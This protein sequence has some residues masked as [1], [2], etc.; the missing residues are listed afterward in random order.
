MKILITGATGFIGQALVAKLKDH[1][2]FLVGRD[3]TKL[4][5]IFTK[6]KDLLT[7][8]Q[9]K[10][11]SDAFFSEL[12]W[13]INL[14]GANIAEKRW[15]TKRKKVIIHSRVGSSRFLASRLAPLGKAAPTLFNASA[16]GFYGLQKTP[17]SN[18]DLGP[19]F[20]EHSLPHK[21]QDFLTNITHQWETALDLAVKAGV[22]VVMMRFGVVLGPGGM[23]N[24]LLLPYQFCMG[25]RVGSGRQVISWIALDDLIN[26]ILFIHQHQDIKG[27][28]NF[29]SPN[30][31][32]QFTFAKTL[33]K[34]LHRPC[35]FPT[36]APL[37]KLVYGQMGDELLLHGTHVSPGILSE[38]D[39][40]Y[41]HPD[42]KQAIEHGLIDD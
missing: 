27:P 11:Q 22:R 3:Q 38:L 40:Q 18:Q 33:A 26:A 14:C 20:N 23:L 28:V 9:L 6:Q 4:R 24:Q 30:A 37:V 32:N 42:I 5:D 21:T 35:V 34:T 29:V 41:T 15:S 8:P 7:W 17:K 12:D 1:Q 25:G 19:S 31:V 2:L 10:Q 39:F 36:V 16:I 13:V